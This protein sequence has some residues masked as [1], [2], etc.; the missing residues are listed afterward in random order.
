MGP[1]FDDLDLYRILARRHR[2]RTPAPPDNTAVSPPQAPPTPRPDSSPARYL[3]VLGRGAESA[4]IWLARGF[5]VSEPPTLRLG[6]A[7][8]PPVRTSARYRTRTL[9]FPTSDL[10][11]TVAHPRADTCPFN[12]ARVGPTLL[13]HATQSENRYAPGTFPTTELH[14]HPHRA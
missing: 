4:T 9:S 13:V 11:C 10:G 14:L 6:T 1:S 3:C 8:I 5:P 2:I 7:Q 12:R